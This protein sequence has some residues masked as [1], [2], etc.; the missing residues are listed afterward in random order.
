MAREGGGGGGGEIGATRSSTS[1]AMEQNPKNNKKRH[2]L[3]VNCTRLATLL[4]V[5]GFT[6]EGQSSKVAHN[7]KS[8][9][10]ADFSVVE[11]HLAAVL[12]V[13]AVLKA[14]ES[15]RVA[16]SP[17]AAVLDACTSSTSKKRTFAAAGA[18]D[19]AEE[20]AKKVPSPSNP[21]PDGLQLLSGYGSSDNDEE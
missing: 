5:V 16:E 14:C 8:K 3:T 15:S 6:N 19:A 4:A 11:P 7:G 21:E 1:S 18:E 13:A 17:P 9:Y 10:Y 2:I 20:P 12:E